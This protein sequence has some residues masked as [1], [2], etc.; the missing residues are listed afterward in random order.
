MPEHILVLVVL[1]NR[2][3]LSPHD[4]RWHAKWLT[5][6]PDMFNDKGLFKLV[7][8]KLTLFLVDRIMTMLVQKCGRLIP[9]KMLLQLLKQEVN[10][11]G[12]HNR[13]CMIAMWVPFLS[14]LSI[15]GVINKC[16]FSG[17]QWVTFCYLMFCTV[18]LLHS[19]HLGDRGNFAIWG[20]AAC[21][22]ENFVILCTENIPIL[23]LVFSKSQ[24]SSTVCLENMLENWAPYNSNS[25]AAHASSEGPQ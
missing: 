19:G 7:K 4:P 23:E 22:F 13:S 16:C 21:G 20:S 25:S 15:S 11:E 12:L 10:H 3:F 6:A 1:S 8:L 18:K 5:T 9:Q 17:C 2:V 24:C 14:I